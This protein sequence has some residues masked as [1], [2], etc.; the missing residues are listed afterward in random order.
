MTVW[1]YQM[2]KNDSGNI[3]LFDGQ[4]TFWN[5]EML[6]SGGYDMYGCELVLSSFCGFSRYGP[7]GKFTLIGAL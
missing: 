6:P 4:N 7:I 1:L 3:V 5:D 2:S